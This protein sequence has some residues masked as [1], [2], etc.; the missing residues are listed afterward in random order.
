MLIL[1]ILLGLIGLG[2]VVIVHELGHFAAARAMGVEVEA[3]SIGWGPR[4][5]GFKRGGTEWRFS[6]F[7]VGGYCKMKGEESFRKALEDKAPEMPRESGSFYGASPWR[8]IVIALSGPAANVLLA[9][10][11][12]IVVSTIGYTTPT[13]SNRIVLLSEYDLGTPRLASYP[14]DK[15]GLKTGDRIV[16]ADGAAISD[17]SDL[18]E[19]ITLS[20]NKPIAL[21]IE[22]DGILYDKTVTPMMDKDTGGGLLGVS[23]WADPIV[24][25]VATGSAAQIAGIESGDRVVSIDGKDIRHA[26][27]AFSLLNSAK[28]ERTKIVVERGGSRIELSVILSWNA[29]GASNLG[30]SFKTETHTVR[31]AT[32]LGAAVSAG[33]SETWST[34]DATLKG[35]GSLFQGV[36]LFKALS[37]PA[38]ITYMVGQ[39][40]TAGIQ[41]S[42][43]GGLALPLS[44]LAFLSIG[45]FIMNLL[46]I[47]ALDGGQVVMF[48]VEGVR[49]KAL[50]P[51]TIYRYQFIGATFILAIFVIATVGDFLFFA[52]K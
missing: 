47:P 45:L 27:E 42:A 10:L 36:N 4:I 5:A 3:F 49:R 50:R 30:M 39:S 31:A 14:A 43:S 48:V 26:V 22:R 51:R 19:R 41:R 2:V 52:A 40:A 20:A 6:A 17:F 37:G 13:Y 38:R 18:L 8:R 24:G 9:L 16:A 46:P 11:V 1:T 15:A 44:F 29:Q 28:P 35:L 21:R 23:Y 25:D 32:T 34:F 12:F 33:F 7:P